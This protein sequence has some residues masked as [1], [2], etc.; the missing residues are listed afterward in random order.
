ML[1]S[2]IGGF[3]GTAGGGSPPAPDNVPAAGD[4]SVTVGTPTTLDGTESL[5]MTATGGTGTVNQIHGLARTLPAGNFSVI[6]KLHCYH[7]EQNNNAGIIF[8]DTAGKYVTIVNMVFSSA[9]LSTVE[10]YTTRTSLT[11]ALT[12][13]QH[14]KHSTPVWLKASFDSG[15]NDVEGFYSFTG[16]NWESLGTSTFL[17]TADAVGIGVMLHY[18]GTGTFTTR[19]WFEHFEVI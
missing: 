19:A 12:A 5:L 13:R 4:F 7:A 16:D 10:Q 11:S 3:F 8:R 9:P 15:T 14:G 6:V 17:G 18:A 2:G 1:I